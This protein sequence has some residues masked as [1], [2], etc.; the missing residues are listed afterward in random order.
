M[1]RKKVTDAKA[2]LFKR[3]YGENPIHLKKCLRFSKGNTMLCTRTAA[4]RQN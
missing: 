4:N 3:L 1:E 2:L